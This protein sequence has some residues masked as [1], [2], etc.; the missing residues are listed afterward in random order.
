[1][2]TLRRLEIPAEMMDKHGFAPLDPATGAVKNAIFGYNSA[3]LYKLDL[4]AFG[5]FWAEVDLARYDSPGPRVRGLVLP[6]ASPSLRC[7]RYRQRRDQAFAAVCTI[8]GDRNSPG[9]K[10]PIVGAALPS[11]ISPVALPVLHHASAIETNVRSAT[12]RT[13]DHPAW[14]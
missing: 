6:P 11:Y 12:W 2:E 4:R 7:L 1:M 10:D 9:S 13:G 3:R 8:C 5:P 14:R